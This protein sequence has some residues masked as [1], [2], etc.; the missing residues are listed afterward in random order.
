MK[1]ISADKI[2]TGTEWITDHV[3]VVKDGKA[4][5]VDVKEG[6]AGKDATEV[7]GQLL[8]HDQILLKASDDI[9]DGDSV[10]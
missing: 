10:K 8:A 9:K 1:I 5:L 4:K 2:F 7:F 6:L 3:I